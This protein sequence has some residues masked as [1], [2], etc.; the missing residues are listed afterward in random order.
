MNH[1]HSNAREESCE[2]ALIIHKIL[3]N[4]PAFMVNDESFYSKIKS[5]TLQILH[6]K[7]VLTRNWSHCKQFIIQFVIA[8]TS[9]LKWICS[10]FLKVFHFHGLGLFKLDY[11]FIFSV[12]IDKKFILSCLNNEESKINC[13]RKFVSAS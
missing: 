2:S 4:K 5:F 3:Q 13:R 6:R 12:N 10:H 1:F 11:T 7:K 9:K 8:L